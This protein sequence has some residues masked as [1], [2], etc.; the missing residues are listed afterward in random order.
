VPIGS[1]QGA[2]ALYATY[3]PPQA[4]IEAAGATQAALRSLAPHPPSLGIDTEVV[5]SGVTIVFVRAWTAEGFVS[6]DN[7]VERTANWLGQTFLVMRGT[8]TGNMGSL[9]NKGGVFWYGN[10]DFYVE[11]AQWP[12]YR[13]RLGFWN[14]HY[15]DLVFSVNVGDKGPFILHDKVD[16]WQVDLTPIFVNP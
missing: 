12:H 5:V 7:Y 2:Q 8:Y 13:G 16:G 3:A 15:F 6:V 9:W 10:P 14:R 11:G 4:T 1:L